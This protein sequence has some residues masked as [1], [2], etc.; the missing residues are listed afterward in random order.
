MNRTIGSRFDIEEYKTLRTEQIQ[1]ILLM[2]SQTSGL[3]TT[4]LSTWGPVLTIFIA[5]ISP[6][7][8]N[9]IDYPFRS[10]K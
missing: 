9:E 2:N 4:I 8:K 1:R 7:L 3:T 10:A 6:F 5:T